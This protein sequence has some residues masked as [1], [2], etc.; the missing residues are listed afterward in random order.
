MRKWGI[1]KKERDAS[2]T[3]SK[4]RDRHWDSADRETERQ[5]HR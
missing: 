2:E 3:K 5:K 1:Q 4:K